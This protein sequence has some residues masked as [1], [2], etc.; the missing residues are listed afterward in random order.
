MVRPR[1]QLVFFSLV[2]AGLVLGSCTHTPTTS[3]SKSEAQRA[4]PMIT[5]KEA[6]IRAKI[7]TQVDYDLDF[8]FTQEGDQY[9]GQVAIQFM[10]LTG[11]RDLRVDFSGQNIIHASLNGKPFEANPNGVYL[12]VPGKLIERGSQR[13]VL[14]FTQEYNRQG[15]GLTRF[16]DPLDKRTYIY[17]D[18]EPYDANVAFPCFDQ[19]DLKATFSVKAKAPKDWEM[20]SSVRENSVQNT[21]DGNHQWSF[22]RSSRF[23]TY[24]FSLHGGPYAKWEDKNFRIPLRLFARRSLAKYVKINEWFP[25]T[26]HG[27]DFFE[28][29]F[30]TP[31]P[32]KKYDQIVVPEF[33]SGAMENVAAVTFNERLIARGEKTRAQ[34][35]GLAN[36][37]LHEMAHMWFGDLVTMRWWG[38]L[39]LNESFAT[40]MASLAMSHSKEFPESWHQ[41]FGGKFG[42]YW[43][44][45]L[46][47]THPV[48]AQ[49]QDT[50]E[51]FTTFDSITYGKGASVLKQFVFTIGEDSFRKGL[52]S[53][54][55][56]Y[57]EKNT[58]Y[59]DFFS[60]MSEASQ[61]DLGDWHKVWFETA[62]LNTIKAQF[63]CKAGQIS[64]LAILQGSVSGSPILRPHA[65]NLAL[66]KRSGSEVL[67]SEVI[68]VD[69][70]A[71][72]NYIAQAV[73]KPCPD[74]VF[75]NYQDY[76][77]FKTLLD[78]RSLNSLKFT[79]NEVK[80][81]L[82]RHQLWFALWDKV[83]DAEFSYIAFADL[84]ATDAVAKENNDMI[85]RYLVNLSAQVLNYF[86]FSPQL[87]A[88]EGKA[89]AERIDQVVLD[90][91]FSARPGQP[92]QLIWLDA[93]PTIVSSPQGL[94]RVKRLLKG[95]D[96]LRGLSLDQDRRWDLL[97]LLARNGDAEAKTLIEIE[98]KRDPSSQG[99]EKRIGALAALPN[100]D[101]KM[102]Y[103]EEYKKDKWTLSYAQLRSAI[104]NIFP[105]QQ[106]ELRQKYQDQYFSDLT[107]VN[108]TKENFATGLFTTL[109]P[110][111]CANG[112]SD[113][114]DQFV[115]KTAN[116]KPV[117]SKALR[118]QAEE[119]RRCLKIIALAEGGGRFSPTAP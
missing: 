47:T 115:S 107:L 103:V 68:R 96:S 108:Q 91:L 58:D 90:R 99:V 44:D 61:K 40:Y 1:M 92:E 16:I 106:L 82:L 83:R 51:A 4:S 114:I 81:D 84:L 43:E 100:W 116:L 35:R 86:D 55:T 7:I 36:V 6:A 12:V 85:S 110:S 60:V 3:E 94:N 105:R 74:V 95:Q 28:E 9:S 64:Q 50:N 33:N 42:A 119:G 59:K 67:V 117:L 39:W 93:L 113:R 70:S 109:S 75:P 45:H 11:G 101:E 79:I 48:V 30:H 65:T 57:A 8:D 69:V 29:Y 87:K 13:L 56:R 14:Q 38:D 24:I 19:P 76:G 34:I 78:D 49:V 104:S 111:A 2:A 25:I 98:A 20:I 112:V 18:F 71:A 21:D 22:P 15:R 73:G 52:E 97:I 102:K 118:N 10:A 77:Y 41:F 46:A 26:R 32:F 89:F 80:D 53:Y 5:M 72:T 31:Y 88:S 62:G 54:F 66:L 27:F 37:I 17:T 63:E 23:S